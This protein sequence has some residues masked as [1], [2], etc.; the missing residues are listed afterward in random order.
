[1]EGTEPL[2]L[3][4]AWAALLA[5]DVSVKAF[6]SGARERRELIVAPLDRVIHLAY[7]GDSGEAREA[8]DALAA[9]VARWRSPILLQG[10]VGTAFA[11]QKRWSEALSAHVAAL[12]LTPRWMCTAAY[13][14]LGAVSVDLLHLGRRAE[15]VRFAERA[16][17]WDP[18]NPEVLRT[19]HDAREGEAA[20][21]APSLADVPKL[22]SEEWLR[23]IAVNGVNVFTDGEEKHRAHA[24]ACLQT[25][26]LEAAL[27]ATRQAPAALS[28]DSSLTPSAA[29]AWATAREA[30]IV[31]LPGGDA[32]RAKVDTNADGTFSED[33]NA[34]F[35]LV[36][37]CLARRE[38]GPLRALLEDPN[39]ELVLQAARALGKL[40]VREHVPQ[41]MAMAEAERAFGMDT[42]VRSARAVL[43]GI[44]RE[45]RAPK[46]S[47]T[48][49]RKAKVS[50][51][52]LAP[53]EAYSVVDAAIDDLEALAEKHKDAKVDDA[54]DALDA[55]VTGDEP[56]HARVK[57]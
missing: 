32:A 50:L 36:S 31:T 29:R 23:C 40:G 37:D 42:G 19:L 18:T 11:K 41:L 54:L 21:A 30:A 17:L 47:K 9:I 24:I 51:D 46:R 35:E 8:A 57:P 39:R 25:G 4:A 12:W 5:R 52:E 26:R 3:E 53:W 34:R 33:L 15:A 28:A 56:D 22:S 1:M 48:A 6:S 14:V 38:P 20:M 7:S 27:F 13:R 44:K 2:D 16:L 10:L 45:L 43:A 49:P 55:L